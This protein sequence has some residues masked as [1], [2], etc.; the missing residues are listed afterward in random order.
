VKALGAEPNTHVDTICL[1]L[2]AGD[3]VVAFSRDLVDRLGEVDLRRVIAAAPQANLVAELLR[4]ADEHPGPPVAAAS[5]GLPGLVVGGEE[6]SRL[7][8]LA[9][10]PL[11]AYCTENE[12]LAV[13]QV[14]LPR[15]HPIGVDLV[16][17]GQFH[18]EVWLVVEGQVVIARDGRQIAM[19]GAGSNFG[20]MSMLDDPHASATVR[21]AT[22]V[23]VLVIPRD[24]FLGLLRAD[25]RFSVKVLWN[26]LLRLSSNLRRT[27]ARLAEVQIEL[28]QAAPVPKGMRRQ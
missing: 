10:M 13:A 19:M 7:S 27:S 16:V 1:D 3:S 24:A 15:A 12:L 2:V 25:P 23:E 22:P 6:R 14:A 9:R 26:M 20:E 18:Q 11:F 28:D 5:A 17:Q 8:V 21:T 4:A